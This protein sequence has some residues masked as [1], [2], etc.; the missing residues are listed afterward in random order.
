MLVHLWVMPYSAAHPI[1]SYTFIRG[2]KFAASGTT[3]V[4]LEG[5]TGSTLQ[6]RSDFM[7]LSQFQLIEI[8]Q[9]CYNT[10][11]CSWIPDYVLFNRFSKNIFTFSLSNLTSIITFLLFEGTL[12]NSLKQRLWH[13]NTFWYVVLYMDQILANVA[14]SSQA[15]ATV[16]T[17]WPHSQIWSLFRLYTSISNTNKFFLYLN[18][19]F[20]NH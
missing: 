18:I 15:S 12:T 1:F 14:S 6:Q 8:I 7:A 13:S 4:D 5:Y 11:G 17:P 16:L 9:L 10:F 20:G 3:L 19:F 2:P